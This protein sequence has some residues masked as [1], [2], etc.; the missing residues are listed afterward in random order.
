[1]FI[2]GMFVKC[3]ANAPTLKLRDSSPCCVYCIVVLLRHS[4]KGKFILFSTSDLGFLMKI[5]FTSPCHSS[6]ASLYSPLFHY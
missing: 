1:M 4:K 5:L 6:G 3:S 2:P